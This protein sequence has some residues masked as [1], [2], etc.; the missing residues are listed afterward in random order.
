MRWKEPIFGVEC[1]KGLPATKNDLWK[2]VKMQAARLLETTDHA[3]APS[4]QATPATSIGLW[5]HHWVWDGWD[6]RPMAFQWRSDARL[7]TPHR[8]HVLDRFISFDSCAMFKTSIMNWMGNYFYRTYRAICA[9]KTG[10]CA[11]VFCWDLLARYRF[12][13]GFSYGSF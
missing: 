13:T 10:A 4:L 8:G 12:S 9:T 1:S 5:L 6:G 2:L 3:F 11:K 7:E